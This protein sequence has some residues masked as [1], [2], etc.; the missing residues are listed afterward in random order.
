[1]IVHEEGAE[2]GVQRVEQVVQG[3]SE[4]ATVACIAISVAPH[5]YALAVDIDTH[6]RQRRQ[7]SHI[8]SRALAHHPVISTATIGDHVRLRKK[9]TAVV[10]LRL[11]PIQLI[12]RLNRQCV[13]EVLRE[14][15]KI[16]RHQTV[17]VFS[18]RST[19]GRHLRRVDSIYTA[20]DKRAFTPV[21][22]LLTQTHGAWLIGN[23]IV[24][25]HERVQPLRASRLR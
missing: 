9:R 7:I 25:V 17:F 18:A 11:L 12:E 2:L 19:I 14:V 6:R 8:Q 23:D 3:Q 15:E 10:D 5:Q 1:M 4:L 13:R 22:H 20:A 16:D 24:V 21:D